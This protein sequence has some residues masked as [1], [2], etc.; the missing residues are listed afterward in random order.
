MKFSSGN[1]FV[2]T[3]EGLPIIEVSVQCGSE[4]RHGYFYIDT[5]SSINIIDEELVT[6]TGLES[7]FRGL[8]NKSSKTRI[9]SV[10]FKIERN[11][12]VDVFH[13]IEKKVIPHEN[14]YDILG[15]LGIKF[16]NKHN[17]IFNNYKK[18]IHMNKKSDFSPNQTV[19]NMDYTEAG[20]PLIQAVF[21]DKKQWCL[22]DTGCTFNIAC[23]PVFGDFTFQPITHG[24]TNVLF[25]FGDK[26][27]TLPAEL[28]FSVT[29][30]LDGK[31]CELQYKEEFDVP[32]CGDKKYLDIDNGREIRVLLG[33]SFIKKH[34]WILDFGNN[35]IYTKQV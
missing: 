33:N 13:A 9:A 15:I 14:N 25:S 23:E 11:S 20:L 8:G 21:N 35:I 3:E 32:V 24:D 10:M 4:E 17:I 27:M 29:Q 28:D 5:G 26:I 7:S 16:M 22:I 19:I 6:D 12:Y 34:R 2:I 31:S 18:V 1:K 30:E